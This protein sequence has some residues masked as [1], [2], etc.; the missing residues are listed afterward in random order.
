MARARALIAAAETGVDL[1]KKESKPDLTLGLGYTLVG[2]RRDPAGRAMPPPDNGDDIL[3]VTL[4]VNLPVWRERIAAGVTEASSRSTAAE[5]ALRA[6]VAGIDGQLDDLAARLPL[7]GEQVRL[8]DRVLAT[9]AEEAL[10]SAESGYAAGS[11]GALDLLDAERV[12]LEV[13]IATARSRADYQITCPDW[14]APSAPRSPRKTAE[15][16]SERRAARRNDPLLGSPAA[17]G[18]RTSDG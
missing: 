18:S 8:F 15:V 4:G 2:G 10:R 1:A 14:R 7:I 17:A 5:D 11:V 12:L 13:R 16:R 6:E 9:Q 3:G